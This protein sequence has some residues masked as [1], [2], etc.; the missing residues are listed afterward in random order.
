MPFPVK[1]QDIVEALE[2]TADFNSH[3]LDRRTGEI[4]MITDEVWDAAENNELI[5]EYPEWQ[6]ESILKAREIQST[7]HF[8]ELPSKFDLNS[9]EMMERFCREYPNRR[10]SERLSAA[11]KGKGA[12]RRFKDMISDLGIQDEWNR[13]EQQSLEDIA[14]EWLEAEGI[15]FTRGD[16]IELSAE[17]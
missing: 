2:M 11:V 13:F 6:R 10:I 9:Y 17:M 12:F 15:P 14:V 7:D 1:L 5:S 4:E 8:I 3:F 16:E